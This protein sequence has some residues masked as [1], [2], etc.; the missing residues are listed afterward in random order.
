MIIIILTSLILSFAFSLYLTATP[1]IIGL[2]IIF[3][4]LSMSLTLNIVITSW[5]AIFIFLIYVGGILVMFSYFIAITPNQVISSNVVI[6]F[7]VTFFL[8][9]FIFSIVISID[10][11]SSFSYNSQSPIVQLLYSHNIAIL[12]LLALALFFALVAVVKISSLNEGPL[13]PFN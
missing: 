8:C 5:L 7:T 10:L 2:W 9:V 11:S 12:S 13:R 4:A 1:T 3:L 6:P